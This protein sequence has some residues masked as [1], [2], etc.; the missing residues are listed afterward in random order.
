MSNAVD[1]NS[2][3][4]F[5]S[6]RASWILYQSN[7]TS[8]SLRSLIQ[9]LREVLSIEDLSNSDRALFGANL[10]T[11]LAEIGDQG[12]NEF[13]LDEVVNLTREA[14]GLLDREQAAVAAKN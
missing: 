14:I 3:P 9:N 5:I 6:L 4:R 7:P 10:A 8:T 11:A 13:D 12:G 2:D 1:A